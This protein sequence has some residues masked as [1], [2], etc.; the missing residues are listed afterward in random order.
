MHLMTKE[1]P[2]KSKLYIPQGENEYPPN[3]PLKNESVKEALHEGKKDYLFKKAKITE[4][5][6]K[7]WTLLLMQG[8][9]PEGYET[10]EEFEN[11]IL[12]IIE[13]ES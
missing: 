10:A 7:D 2:A 8:Q 3:Y 1:H 6:L 12:S 9:I 4:D 13:E 5:Q 11:Y